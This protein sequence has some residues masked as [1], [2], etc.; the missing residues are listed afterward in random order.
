MEF[1]PAENENQQLEDLPQADLAVY[2]K[3]FFCR[4]NFNNWEFAYWKLGHCLFCSD[5][6]HVFILG[7]PTYFTIFIQ[8]LSI[9]FFFI[10]SFINKVDFASQ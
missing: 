2:L 4:Y 10:H 7:A 8:G 6:T 3:D 1:L 5:L 9:F